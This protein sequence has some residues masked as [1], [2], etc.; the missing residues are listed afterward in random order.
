[1]Q[2]HLLHP[3]LTVK[4]AMQFSVNLKTGKELSANEK[5]QRVT[6]TKL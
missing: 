3:L 6:I 2:E 1:M 5:Q 4:E